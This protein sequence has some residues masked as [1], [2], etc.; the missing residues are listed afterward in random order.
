MAADGEKEPLDGRNSVLKS[1]GIAVIWVY[2]FVWR[3][4][5]THKDLHDTMR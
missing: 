1:L 5:G 3:I 4:G 2:S